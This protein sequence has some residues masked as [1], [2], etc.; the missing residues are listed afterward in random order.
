M[1]ALRD[2]SVC[3]KAA[4]KHQAVRHTERERE[5]TRAR[6]RERERVCVRALL[7]V[8]VTALML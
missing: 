1:H 3:S 8:Y 2:H 7:L 5:S 6:A 4:V